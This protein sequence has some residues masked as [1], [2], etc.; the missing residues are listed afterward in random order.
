M[1]LHP[2]AMIDKRAEL[3]AD[4][5]VGPY[6][7][8]EGDVR[9]AAGTRIDAHAHVSQG[10]RIGRDC[11]IHPFAVVSHLPQDTKFDGARSYCRIGDG[12]IIREHATLHRGTLP[13][14]E[15]IVGKKCFIMAAAH[16]G[17][18]CTVGDSVT[19]VNAVLLAG[20][21]AVGDRAFIAGGAA[22]HQFVRIGE[23]TMV[24]GCM[25]VTSDIPPYMTAGPH[26][27]IGPNVVGLRRAGL[28]AD[29]RNEL[30]RCYRELFRSGRMFRE[31]LDAVEPTVRTEHGR[32][33]MRFLREPSKRGIRGAPHKHTTMEGT[34]DA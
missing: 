1:P 26:G 10:A 27:L 32:R 23:L 16:V 25:R 3:D 20:H 21:V 11:R 14:S 29:E 33:L 24:S 18:N 22:I 13:E 34:A 31:A 4:V 17:H 6:A 30:R 7:I 15:T 28:S 5:E 8:I 2:T 19:L 12:T 9:I